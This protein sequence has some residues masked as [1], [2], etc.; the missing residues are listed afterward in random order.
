MAVVD[1]FRV[2]L[3]TLACSAAHAGGR[4]EDLAIAHLSS[5][6]RIEAAQPGWVGTSAAAL[7]TRMAAWLATSRTLLSGV[8]DHA[9]GLHDAAIGFAAMEQE[10]AE[11][12]REVG[13][14]AHGA[15]RD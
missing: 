9:Q 14:T 4:G 3:E 13:D 10:N 8:G 1:E 7:N 5:D 6:N 15:V 11:A 12:L 2:G